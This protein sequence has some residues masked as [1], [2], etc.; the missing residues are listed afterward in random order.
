A[1]D[2]SAYALATLKHYRLKLAGTAAAPHL[3]VGFP[4]GNF[5]RRLWP[6]VA[7]FGIPYVVALGTLA[8]GRT[9][10]VADV[11]D[12]NARILEAVSDQVVRDVIA[13]LR[14]RG[15]LNKAVT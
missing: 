6:L 3:R 5:K 12:G 7:E 9:V 4:A 8:G 10:Y 14:Q 2:R 13:D 15:E 1:Y 11:A